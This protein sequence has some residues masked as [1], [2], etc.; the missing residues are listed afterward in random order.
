MTSQQEWQPTPQDTKGAP[1]YVIDQIQQALIS[2]TLTPGERL[3]SESE[4]AASFHVSRGSIRQ[5]MKALE[6]LGIVTIRPGNGTYINKKPTSKSFN[7]LSYA[8]LLANP[9]MKMIVEARCSLERDISELI[10]K[11]PDQI[12]NILPL[13][14]DNLNHHRDLLTQGADA[15]KLVENDLAFH[16]ILSRNCNNTILQIVYDYVMDAFATYMRKTQVGQLREQNDRTLLD[17]AKIIQA[18]QKRNFNA[19]KDVALITA[20]AW[21]KLLSEVKL[22]EA[23]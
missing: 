19:A 4:L 3:P 6:M 22:H 17:H 13:L 11:N 10:L 21:Y 15:Y 9:N 14:E 16:R 20:D 2:G 8:L 5:A 7:P 12:D 23:N 1:D 18:L